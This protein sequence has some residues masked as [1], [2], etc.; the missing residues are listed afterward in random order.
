MKNFLKI[1]PITL[2]ILLYPAFQSMSQAQFSGERLHEAVR[3]YAEKVLKEYDTEIVLKRG[4][5]DQYFKESG[6]TAR[7]SGDES[8]I[9]T[10][11]KVRLEFVLNERVIKNIDIPLQVKVFKKLACAVRELPRGTVLKETDIIFL[12]KDVSLINEQDIPQQELLIGQ[13]I[14]RPVAKSGIIASNCVMTSGGIKRNNVV[15]LVVNIGGVFI[16][17]T[18]KALNDAGVGESVRISRD[19]GMGTV[20]GKVAHDGTVLVSAR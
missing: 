15:T 2:A 7:I 10:L 12:K 6:V 14:I 16:T 17:T 3:R 8:S 13:T 19:N 5:P 9:L 4:I 11:Q 20:I 1:F 18:G